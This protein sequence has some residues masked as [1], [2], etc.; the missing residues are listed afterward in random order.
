MKAGRTVKV[1][2]SNVSCTIVFITSNI[3]EI[4]QVSILIINLP[5]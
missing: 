3:L 1:L 4:I 2:K 5:S